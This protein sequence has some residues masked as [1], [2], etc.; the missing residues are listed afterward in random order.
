MFYNQFHKSTSAAYPLPVLSGR[1]AI[2]MALADIAAQNL[3]SPM[4]LFFALG[5]AAALARSDLAVPEAVAKLLSLY[6][7]MSIGFTGRRRG[8]H[9]G[10]TRPLATTIGAGVLS[11]RPALRRLRSCA[12]RRACRRSTRPPSPAITVRSPP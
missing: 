11:V 8:R 2:L 10:L 5:F 3:L 4:A 12:R 7:L 9:H 1:K 6:L